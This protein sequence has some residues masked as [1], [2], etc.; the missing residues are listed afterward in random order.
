VLG[1]LLI[2]APAGRSFPA[3]CPGGMFW[4]GAVWPRPAGWAAD[5]ARRWQLFAGSGPDLLSW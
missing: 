1:H 3:D 2:V 5:Q 4:T